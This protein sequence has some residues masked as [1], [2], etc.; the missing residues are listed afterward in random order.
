MSVNVTMVIMQSRD[1]IL[2][3]QEKEIE[4]LVE[5]LTIKMEIGLEDINPE[6]NEMDVADYVK[7]GHRWLT[8]DSVEQYI[9]DQ[10][11]W[12]WN[13]MEALDHDTEIHVLKEINLFALKLVDGISHVHAEQ[14]SDNN[15]ALKLAPSIMPKE[16]VMM[17][18][19]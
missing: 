16:L 15:A 4:V 13:L 12:A 18:S 11:S 17:R 6:Y 1:M 9:H 3:Q 10:E 2:S 5:K 19:N 8:T 14:D 7:H